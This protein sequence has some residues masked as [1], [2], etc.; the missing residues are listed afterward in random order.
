[1]FDERLVY[2]ADAA[3]LSQIRLEAHF[4]IASA[5]PW[6]DLLRNT[7]VAIRDSD[8]VDRPSVAG[9]LAFGRATDRAHDVGVRGSL[10]ATAA[11]E[12]PESG[13]DAVSS[14]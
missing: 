4:G 13:D 11:S 3:D 9:P 12:S 7:R 6:P 14:S 1:M 10:P 5:I 2:S 8:G